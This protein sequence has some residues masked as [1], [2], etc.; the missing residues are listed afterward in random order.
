MSETSIKDKWEKIQGDFIL[1]IFNER[2]SP[3]KNGQFEKINKKSRNS[4]N[5]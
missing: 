4:V 1:N 2:I 3:F 5:I